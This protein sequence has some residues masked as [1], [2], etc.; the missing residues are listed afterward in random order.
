[1]KQSGSLQL[2]AVIRR[3]RQAQ[4]MSMTEFAKEIGSTQ[5]TVSR[6]EAGKLNP[7][8][9]VLLLLLQLAEG[10]ERDAILGY[11]GVEP[12]NRAA[13]T[14]KQLID[15]MRIFEEYLDHQG[16]KPPAEEV[17]SQVDFARLAKTILI[18]GPEPDL[19]LTRLLELWLV[20]GKTRRFREYFRR[21]VHYLEV[22]LGAQHHPQNE[23]EI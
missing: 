7:S 20:H 14:A 8:R 3:I 2:P 11:L 13:A 4:K 12:R 22:E 5:S 16:T 21:A 18:N 17:P 15:S 9:T 19:S 23:L 6:Y 1:V 10:P